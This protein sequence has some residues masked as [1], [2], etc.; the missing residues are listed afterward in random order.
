M[1]VTQCP[2]NVACTAQLHTKTLNFT[3]YIYMCGNRGSTVV[4]MLCYKS[5][6]R[7]FDPSW[8]HLT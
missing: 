3:Q 2:V 8:Y 6:D 1:H 7:R 4:K 5:E